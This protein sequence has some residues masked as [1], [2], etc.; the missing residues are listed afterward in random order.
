LRK[1]SAFFGFS[2]AAWEIRVLGFRTSR[3]ESGINRDL[4]MFLTVLIVTGTAVSL[5]TLYVIATQAAVRPALA[6]DN[7][8]VGLADPAAETMRSDSPSRPRADWQ[9]ATVDDLTD[10]EDLLD[11]LECR[12]YEDRELVVLGNSCFAVRWR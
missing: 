12:G 7:T 5:T 4:V 9:L 10:A 3:A 11:S 2:P 1:L 6:G 8:L